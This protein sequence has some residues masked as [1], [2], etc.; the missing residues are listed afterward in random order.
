MECPVPNV[1][2]SDALAA[3][4]VSLAL[5][6]SLERTLER[7]TSFKVLAGRGNVVE[8]NR[9]GKRLKIIDSTFNANIGSMSGD[10]RSFKTV[11][12]RMESRVAVLGDIAEL[13]EQSIELHKSL[14][15]AVPEAELSRLFLCGEH[16]KYLWDEIKGQ[17][18][19]EWFATVEELIASIDERL[20]DGDTI[21][22]KA[23]HATHLN[24]VR[25]FLKKS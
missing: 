10:L 25:D 23:S 6:Y 1:Q 21:L 15:S 13:G 5:G 16:M 2:I 9:G 3:V 18:D 24:A 20:R 11:E 17:V 12:P 7:L 19:G 14:S 22:I 4:G 8:V